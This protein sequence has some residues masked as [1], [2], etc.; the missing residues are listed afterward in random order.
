VEYANPNAL[1][2]TDELARLLGRDG[3]QVLDGSFK[4][5]GVEPTAREDY[6]ARHIPGAQFFDIDAV[7]DRSSP[8]PHM[9]PTA[10]EFAAAVGALGI[11]NDTRVIV[12]DAPGPISAPRVWWTFRA[13]GHDRVAVLDGGLRKWIAEGRPLTAEVSTPRRAS[14]AARFRPE[15][16]RAKEQIRANLASRAEQVVDARS[17]GRFEGTEPESW[18]GRRS[19]HIPGS[20]SLPSDQ[21]LDAASGTYLEA[22]ALRRRLE[23]AGIDF[24]RPVAASCGSGVTA[25]AIAFGLYLLEHENASVYDGSWAEWGLPGD[26]PVELGPARR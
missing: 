6:L 8:L 4:M 21:L 15:L 17:R 3:V 16:L 18:P 24:A 1:I 22:P 13:F 25:C 11:S 7:A 2:S 20:L 26:A 10:A 12:Y 9:L 5:P 19:G 23:A 14:F